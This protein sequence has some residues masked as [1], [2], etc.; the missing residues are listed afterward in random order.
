MA[1][2]KFEAH[3]PFTMFSLSNYLGFISLYFIFSLLLESV[4]RLSE[5]VKDKV[6]GCS[7]QNI[8]AVQSYYS[9]MFREAESQ[10]GF[11]LTSRLFTDIQTQQCEIPRC[12]FTGALYCLED[13]KGN[14]TSCG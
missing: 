3:I 2:N 11:N 1:Y 14:S 4:D 8:S 9:N 13:L 7:R 12:S 5:C 10:C 6:T